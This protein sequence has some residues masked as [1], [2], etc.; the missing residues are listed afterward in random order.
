MDADINYHKN[1]SAHYEYSLKGSEFT[2]L[3]VLKSKV[4]KAMNEL[5]GWCS[6]EK[7]SILIDMI[8]ELKPD[9]IVEIGVFG[10]KSLIPMAFALKHNNNGVIYGVD[11]WT[12]EASSE[13]MDGVNLEWWSSIDHDQILKGLQSKIVQFKLESEVELIQSTSE[14]C[15]PIQ[16]INILHID[17]NH[18]EK[19]SLI[20]VLKWVPLVESGG[21]I[22]FDDVNWS[23]TKLATDWLNKNCIKL[24]EYRGDNIWGVWA[25]P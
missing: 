3:M 16:K 5:Q 22:I 17:G 23:T 12:A 8:V 7:A 24:A 25:K 13:G 4:F 11:P 15:P 10:G 19:T 14:E 18:S 1:I 6:Q 2:R 21:I 9:V 20:D